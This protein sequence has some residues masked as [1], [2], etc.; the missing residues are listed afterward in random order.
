MPCAR[1]L[2]CCRIKDDQ[3]HPPPLSKL[4][5]GATKVQAVAQLLHTLHKHVYFNASSQVLQRLKYTQFCTT[6]KLEPLSCYT[7]VSNSRSYRCASY[8]CIYRQQFSRLP[9][10]GNDTRQPHKRSLNHRC[11]TEAL[12]GYSGICLKPTNCLKL[13][14]VN[15]ACDSI[16]LFH[17][18]LQL[19]VIPTSVLPGSRDHRKT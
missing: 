18:V 1:V 16:S 19:F 17:S 2:I 9:G 3:R 11:C 8:R 15:N 12:R 6:Q 13:N 5:T 14:R 7:M 10:K 4:G